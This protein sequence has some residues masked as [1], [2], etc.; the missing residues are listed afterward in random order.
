MSEKS[1]LPAEFDYTTVPGV[2]FRKDGT[3]QIPVH[4]IYASEEALRGVDR[5]DQGYQELA[6]SVKSSGVIEP[7][8]VRGLYDADT[9]TFSFN[10]INGA[11]R[12]SASKDAGLETVPARVMSLTE[13]EVWRTQIK[14]NANRVETKPVQ[15][16]RHL[17]RLLEADATLTLSQIAADVNKHPTWVSERLKLSKLSPQIGNLVDE[18][19]IKLVNAQ[20][21]VKLPT[22]LQDDF[23]E[24]AM[25]QTNA[26]FTKL[27]SDKL[28]DL[29]KDKKAGGGTSEF[30]PKAKARRAEEIEA[31]AANVA[32]VKELLT[33][34]AASTLAEAVI[35]GLNYAI[36]L[37][38]A[39]IELAKAEYEA[40]K[41]AA[42]EKRKESNIVRQRKAVADAEYKTKRAS[43]R[44]ELYNSGKTDEE[45]DTLLTEWDKKHEAEV[46]AENALAEA[47]AQVEGSEES[48]E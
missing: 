32:L 40:K 35:A 23:V 46:A 2:E 31:A 7:I 25:T 3:M 1:L 22:E 48:N 33:K 28:T 18:G 39:S 8:Q 38:P 41:K 11:Q 10:I 26:E 44:L 34:T 16:S 27:V 9:E 30:Q 15:Y 20:Q 37:D 47:Q 14:A 5:K 17:N 36:Q 43:Y 6:S 12:Y 42:D 13:L 24:P 45:V 19:V 29:K 4:M 21:L